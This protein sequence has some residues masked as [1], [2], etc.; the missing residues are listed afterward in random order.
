MAIIGLLF[1]LAFLV[2]LIPA[3]K[4]ATLPLVGFAVLMTGT[5][6][7]PYFMAVEAGFQLSLDRVLWV[8]MLGIYA[9]FWKLGWVDPKALSRSDILLLVF[10]ALLALSTQ[11]GSTDPEDNPIARWLFYILLPLGVYWVARSAPITRRDLNGITSGFVLLG[12]YLGVLGFFE[13]R[14]WH[15]LIF[16]SYIGDPKYFD[17]YGRARGPVM[18]PAGNGVLLG[19]GLAAAIL[20]TLATSG[21]KRI[22]YLVACMVIMLGVYSTLT[23]GV[24]IGSVLIIGVI[25]MAHSPR[26]LRV[27]GVAAALLFG[28]VMA[29]GLKDQLLT[30]KRDKYLSA[31]DSAKSVQLR[32]LLAI[33][34]LEMFKDAPVLGH[35]YGHYEP[36]SKPYFAERAYDLPLEQAREYMQHNILLSLLVDSGLLGC[37]IYIIL[38][39]IWTAAAWRLWHDRSLAPEVR[40]WGL[41]TLA[42]LATY[43]FNAMFQDVSVMPMIQMYALYLVGIV[44]GLHLQQGKLA[45]QTTAQAPWQAIFGRRASDR[46]QPAL[47]GGY[48]NSRAAGG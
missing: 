21:R 46:L 19:I 12:V 13:T 11:L 32:P 14:E 29:L 15:A 9:I 16:P 8:L 20:R 33:V 36:A 34:A 25:A 2:W 10:V 37:G 47:P 31:E 48:Q 40:N 42:F 6:F 45:D 7:G 22:V 3:L 41:L 38:L 27:W 4:H 28:S 44:L 39:I 17:F 24:W 43:F 5:F 18:N 35:G 30:L 1:A 26:W 23:R